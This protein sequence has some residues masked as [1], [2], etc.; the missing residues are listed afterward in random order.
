[1]VRRSLTTNASIFLIGGFA[2]TA[3]AA[4]EPTWYVVTDNDVHVRCGADSSYYAFA[5]AQEGD[6]VAVIGEKYNYARIQAVGSVFDEAYGYVKY[7]ESEEGRFSLSDDGRVGQTLGATPILAPNLN[8]N[9][10]AHSWRQLCILPRGS[11]LKVIETW[12]A[13][14]DGLHAV[15][16]TVHRVVL[17]TNAEGWVNMADLRPAT[18]SEASPPTAT[19]TEMIEEA[20]VNAT[21]APGETV[22]VEVV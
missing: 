16:H 6:L 7:P 11:D 12:T 3:M 9:D 17:P 5:T 13:E 14:K 21:E 10:L 19:L 4:A 8:T 22:E 18:T 2:L 15:P 1:M 20:S